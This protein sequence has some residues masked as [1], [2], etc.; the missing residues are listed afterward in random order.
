MRFHPI[1]LILLL[2]LSVLHAAQPA[3]KP[4]PE[5]TDTSNEVFLVSLDNNVLTLEKRGQQIVYQVTNETVFNVGGRE[6]FP[7]KLLK[8]GLGIQ[9]PPRE[10]GSTLS[11]V[12]VTAIFKRDKKNAKDS[13]DAAADPSSPKKDPFT[14]FTAFDEE[15]ISLE[16]GGRIQLQRVDEFTAYTVGVQTVTKDYL[17]KG[18]KITPSSTLPWSYISSI[19]ISPIFKPTNPN[20]PKVTEETSDTLNWYFVSL[21]DRLLTLENSDLWYFYLLGPEPHFRMGK[22]EI[23]RKILA[24]GMKVLEP[25]G[26]A[27][28]VLTEVSII[29]IFKMDPSLK[30]PS[31][32]SIDLATE[33]EW[34]FDSLSDDGLLFVNK[35]GIQQLCRVDEKTLFEMEGSKIKKEYLKKGMHVTLS[36]IDPWSLQTSV[37]LITSMKKI[38]P[39]TTKLST[40]PAKP[41]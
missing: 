24:P 32:E 38:K 13:A 17:K 4:A 16:I 25:S 10:P 15:A 11:E 35:D 39:S 14:Y 29:P 18:M 28:A 37:K 36:N 20:D 2:S 22:E 23:P 21:D 31:P 34:T 8:P 30:S 7:K 6:T 3:K 9:L 27:G 1:G 19:N 40:S 12:S 41:K 33:S 5:P 26:E